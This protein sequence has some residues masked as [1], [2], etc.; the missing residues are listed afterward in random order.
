MNST[1]GRSTPSAQN[2]E[3]WD[4]AGTV[5][6]DSGHVLIADPCYAPRLSKEFEVTILSQDAFG[7]GAVPQA[8]V[9][10]GVVAQTGLGDGIYD[11]WV[12]RVEVEPGDTRIAQLL[13]DFKLS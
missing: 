2:L 8:G 3:D 9:N 4:F 7:I 11:V 10:L 12:K 13:I 6:I 1:K 5:G